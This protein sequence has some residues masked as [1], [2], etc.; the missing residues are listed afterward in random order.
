MQEETTKIFMT[1]SNWKKTFGL[2]YKKI[3]VLYKC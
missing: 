1:V 3:F 2:L